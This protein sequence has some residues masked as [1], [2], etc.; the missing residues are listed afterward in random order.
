MVLLINSLEHGHAHTDGWTDG[1]TDARVHTH[2]RT[3]TR[4]VPACDQCSIGLK[5]ISV[6][7]HSQIPC[8]TY[9]CII[10]IINISLTERKGRASRR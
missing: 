10:T 6:T 4:G 2:T 5:K 1:Q 9:M 8:T 7:V 3:E